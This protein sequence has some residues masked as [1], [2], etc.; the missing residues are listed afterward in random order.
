MFEIRINNVVSLVG[1]IKAALAVFFSSP[2]FTYTKKHTQYRS[3]FGSIFH[4]EHN[5]L[6]SILSINMDSSLV[7]SMNIFIF[8]LT[9]SSVSKTSQVAELDFLMIKITKTAFKRKYAIY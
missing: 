7:H 4:L 6:Y 5:N 2:N 8:M 1:F 3:V 9:R